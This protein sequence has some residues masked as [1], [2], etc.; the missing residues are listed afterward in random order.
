MHLVVNDPASENEDAAPDNGLGTMSSATSAGDSKGEFESHS[1]CS[2]ADDEDLLL[3][4]A[5]PLQGDASWTEAA[6]KLQQV[7]SAVVSSL[8][9]FPAARSPLSRS[10]LALVAARMLQQLETDDGPGASSDDV[11]S[12]LRGLTS[13]ASEN[14]FNLIPVLP[15]ERLCT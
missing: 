3:Y 13:L 5:E 12:A 11:Q 7:Q 6:A 2:A 1:Q 9:A 14:A 8:A 10:Q 4:A 15:P